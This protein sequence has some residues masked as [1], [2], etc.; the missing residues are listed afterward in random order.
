MTTNHITKCQDILT[1]R[2]LTPEGQKAVRAI[3]LFASSEALRHFCAALGLEPIMSKHRTTEI[4]E[5]DEA[6]GGALSLISEDGNVSAA[7]DNPPALAAHMW[8]LTSK[9]ISRVQD[10]MEHI[11]DPAF[12]DPNMDSQI[13]AA[14]IA[15]S[16]ITKHN[17]AT[18]ALNKAKDEAMRAMDEAMRAMDE[19]EKNPELLDQVGER[20]AGILR[21]AMGEMTEARKSAND[22]IELLEA[23]A[24]NILN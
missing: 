6:S 18:S 7:T 2:G 20:L 16:A 21:S 12:H 5:A 17:S 10:A 1:L 22:D 14:S 4:S 19:A 9:L 23:K 24:R 13:G 8:A 15:I 3:A 11:L